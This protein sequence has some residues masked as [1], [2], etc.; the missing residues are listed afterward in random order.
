MNFRRSLPRPATNNNTIAN[1]TMQTKIPDNSRIQ[2]SAFTASTSHYHQLKGDMVGCSGRLF[3][4][5]CPSLRSPG[6]VTLPPNGADLHHS[7]FHDTTIDDKTF[8]LA[9]SVTGGVP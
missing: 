1:S 7:T 5:W 6:A 3:P 4:K 8:Q 2:R 9:F